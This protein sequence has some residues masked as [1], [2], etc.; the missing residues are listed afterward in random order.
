MAGYCYY[1]QTDNLF[2]LIVVVII[3]IFNVINDMTGFKS[4]IMKGFSSSIFVYLPIPEFFG[5]GY[6]K[7]WYS[8]SISA[9]SLC[10]IFRGCS[11]YYKLFSY[12]KLLRATRVL[13]QIKYWK[14]A[15]IL[16]HLLPHLNNVVLLLLLC[17]TRH[18]I[19]MYKQL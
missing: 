17:E 5:G 10:I 1:I 6:S 9:I 13:T 16:L 19:Y 3:V 11:E 12:H 7:I 8:I 4:M 2:L 15:T 18:C 14:L